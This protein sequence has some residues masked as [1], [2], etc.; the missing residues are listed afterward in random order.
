MDTNS[1]LIF[2]TLQSSS[3]TPLPS[4]PDKGK[5]PLRPHNPLCSTSIHHALSNNLSPLTASSIPISF[6]P[7]RTHSPSLLYVTLTPSAPTVATSQTSVPTSPTSNP[8]P[9]ALRMKN[10]S[11][12]PVGTSVCRPGGR[13]SAPRLAM[14]MGTRRLPMHW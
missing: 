1:A 9:A 6:V 10:N 2:Q 12:R 13:A 3:L 8:H 4:F 11:T 7:L 14:W 5:V